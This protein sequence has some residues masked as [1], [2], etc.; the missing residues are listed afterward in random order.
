M[1]RLKKFIERGAGRKPGRTAYAFGPASLPEPTVGMDWRSVPS[2]NAAEEL[3]QNAS[4][5]E[6]FK[7]AIAKGYAVV[8]IG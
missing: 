4:L 8:P 2:F 6:V 1:N 5:K 7:T 3:L